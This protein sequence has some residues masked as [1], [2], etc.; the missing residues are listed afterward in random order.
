M[1][2]ELNAKQKEDSRES[3][4]NRTMNGKRLQDAL[5]LVY[6]VFDYP[7]AHRGCDTRQFHIY[8]GFGPGNRTFYG[9]TSHTSEKE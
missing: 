7:K 2:R 4:S 5:V 3:V 8:R 6:L 1:L 9:N